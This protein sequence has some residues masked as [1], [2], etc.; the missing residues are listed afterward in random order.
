MS[1]VVTLSDGTSWFIGGRAWQDLAERAADQLRLA[2]EGGLADAFEDFGLDLAAVDATDRRPISE[3]LLAAAEELRAETGGGQ[4]R[5]RL[6]R[7]YLDD[8][9]GKLQSELN[10]EGPHDPDR[11]S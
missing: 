10:A 1:A 4:E 5:E 8:L 11:P 6:L 2:H 7:G 3:A 9:V